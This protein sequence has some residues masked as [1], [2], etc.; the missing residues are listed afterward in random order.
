MQ[1]RLAREAR[2]RQFHC[3]STSTSSIGSPTLAGLGRPA[4]ETP[5]STLDKM[6]VMGA[7]KHA[8]D[9][10]IGNEKNVL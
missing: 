3:C 5:M 10:Q 7:G 9:V 4:A 6:E 2:E 1:N 8:I